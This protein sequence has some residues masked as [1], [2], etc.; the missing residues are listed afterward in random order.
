[1]RRLGDSIN[2]S[3]ILAVALSLQATHATADGSLREA[4]RLL[5]ESHEQDS[6]VGTTSNSQNRFGAQLLALRW[7]QGRIGEVEV[8]LRRAVDVFPRQAGTRA[9]LA[10]V[11]V[12]TGQAD[13]ARAEL[14]RLLEQPVE[15][16]P[17]DFFWWF[18]C[19]FMSHTAIAVG[20]T[21]AARSLYALMRP[22]AQRNAASAG[23]VSF[24][25][26]ELILAMLAAFLEE[27]D[28]AE[29]HFEAALAFN[30]RTRQRVWT[31]RTQFHFADMLLSAGGAEDA[32]RAQELARVARADALEIGMASLL[33]QLSLP[34][35]A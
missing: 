19:V 23:A 20:F 14:E 7:H 4:R 24:G 18:T 6:A 1:M 25:S 5:R 35:F 13:S 9:S 3:G 22:Y 32:G 15:A 27:R 33:A 26:A 31:A 2:A 12:E 30:V 8:G 21:D 16:I 29:R 17:R 11:Y 34:P 10:F 28:A